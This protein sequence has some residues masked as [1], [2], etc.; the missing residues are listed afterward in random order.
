VRGGAGISFETLDRTGNGNE[1]CQEQE[2]EWK[3]IYT[4]MGGKWKKKSI[5]ADFYL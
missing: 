1:L 3:L 5:L 4:K 2:R